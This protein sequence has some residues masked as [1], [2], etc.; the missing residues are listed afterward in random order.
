MLKVVVALKDPFEA[1]D[2]DA[3]ATGIA[4]RR[5]NT[6]SIDRVLIEFILPSS[7]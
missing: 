6:D 5:I 2:S 7:P 1:L 4:K 3:I